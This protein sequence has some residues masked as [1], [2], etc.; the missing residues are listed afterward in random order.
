MSDTT[1]PHLIEPGKWADRTAVLDLA[2][3]LARFTRL[4]DGALSN[5]GEVSVHLAFA[6]DAR[7]LPVLAG[8]LETMLSLE[9]QRCLQA[10]NVPLSAQVNVFMLHDDADVERLSEA[11]DFVLADD[12]ELDFPALLEDELILALPLVASHEDC[13]AAVPLTD[14][15]LAEPEVL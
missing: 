5:E 13:E 4:L 9:C 7:H 3:P 6:R 14:D 12:G 1:L 10:V 8:R 2:V 15:T 11:E